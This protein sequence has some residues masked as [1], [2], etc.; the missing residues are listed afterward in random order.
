MGNTRASSDGSISYPPLPFGVADIL[1]DLIAREIVGL[2]KPVI[3]AAR[4]IE[5]IM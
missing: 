3:L 5:I 1:P 4:P 2:L